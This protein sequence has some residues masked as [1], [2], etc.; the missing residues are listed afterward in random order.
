MALPVWFGKFI[1]L[2]DVNREGERPSDKGFRRNEAERGFGR[3]S[4]VASE[5]L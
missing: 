4:D 2:G 3:R 1:A 5:A